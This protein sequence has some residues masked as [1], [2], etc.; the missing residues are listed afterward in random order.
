MKN[1][2]L[3]AITFMILPGC[4]DLKQSN[5]DKVKPLNIFALCEGNYGQNNAS[6]WSINPEDTIASGPLYK[7]I[8]N[9]PM[10]DIAQSLTLEEDKLFVVNNNSHSV[11]VF[12]LGG[13]SFS[14]EKSIALPGASPRYMASLNQKAYVTCWYLN[15]IVVFNLDTYAIEDTIS[16]DGLPESILEHDGYLYVSITMNTD[17]SSANRIVKLNSTGTPAQTYTV[18]QGPGEMIIHNNALYTAGVYYDSQ[19]NT[20]AGTSRI[21][22]VSGTVTTKDYGLTFSFG[23]DLVLINNTVHRIYQGGLAPLNQDLSINEFGKIG[24]ESD[25]YSAS[26]FGDYIIFGLTDYAAPDIVKVFDTSGGL[27][28]SYT[29]GAIPGDFIVYEK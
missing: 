29:V 13:E 3:L 5:D 20:Y 6:L 8:Y 14:H 9:K 21:D 17:W 19:W 15:G 16:L 1:F 10:G 25:L 23:S 24:N 26:A 11:E 2:L 12:Y 7:N 28:Q 18:I 22:L 4:E 27:I